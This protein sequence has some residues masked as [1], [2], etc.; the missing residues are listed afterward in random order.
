[1]AE[2]KFMQISM[3]RNPRLRQTNCCRNSD[4]YKW[5][6]LKLGTDTIQ[7]VSTRYNRQDSSLEFMRQFVNDVIVSSEMVL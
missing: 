2:W 1:M 6:Q 7:M 5:T 4:G 3:N